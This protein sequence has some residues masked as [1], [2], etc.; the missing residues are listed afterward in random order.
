MKICIL[1]PSF[2]EAKTI[3]GLVKSVKQL[4]FDVMVI[5]DGSWDNTAQV[6]RESGAEIIKNNQNLGKG[7]SLRKAFAILAQSDYD[8]VITM[9]GDGQHLPVDIS[10][11]V[12]QYRKQKCGLIIGNRMSESKGM[13]LIRWITNKFMSY[14]IS[15][16]CRQQIADSQCGFRLIDMG[17]LKKMNLYTDNFEIESEILIEAAKQGQG[18]VSV[19]IKT[20]YE[21]QYSAIHPVADT[22]RFFKFIFNRR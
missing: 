5:D 21:G 6:S 7:A 19:P 11:F 2:N 10:S 22:I 17:L 1:I 14:L 9:D 8:A 3:G 4:G 16:K 13:P 12:E 20:V 15:K 18:I